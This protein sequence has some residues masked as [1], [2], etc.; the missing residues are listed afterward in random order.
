MTKKT[1]A[2]IGGGLA[3]TEAAHQLS[4]NGIKV[5]LFEMRPK[6]R[7]AIHETPY[8]GEL[9]CSNSLGSEEITSASG[10]LKAELLLL[11]SFY[12]NTVLPFRVPAGASLSIDRLQSAQAIDA[13]ISANSNISVVREE[14]KDIPSGFDAV[15]IAT[16]PLTSQPFA[17]TLQKITKR[18]HL[19]F[20]DATSPVIK[21]DSIDYDKVFRASRYGKGSADFLNIALDES[22]YFDF[23]AALNTAECVPLNEADSPIFYE[24]CLPVEEIARRGPLSLAYGPLKPV[25]LT[26]PRSGRVPFA[27]VQLRQ[28]DLHNQFYQLVGFQTRLKWPEQ[29]RIFSTLPGLNSVKF[30][31]F[32]RMHRNTYINAPLII[33]QF[34]RCKSDPKLVFCGQISGVEGYL[35]SI[36]SGLAASLFLFHHLNDIQ[37]QPLPIESA[38]GSLINAISNGNWK[39][40]CPTNFTFGLLPQEHA[41][42]NSAKKDQKRIKSQRA[43]ECLKNWKILN[44]I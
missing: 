43:L 38:T 30:E 6:E 34:F 25:G 42:K 27:V 11:N 12:L 39:S 24:S 17:Q 44:S 7:T 9:V 15:I 10:L 21:A 13:A 32:G 20:Y 1:V 33:D 31:R 2:V 16:G 26:N 18:R 8:M 5:T 22:Q 36:A 28:D 14:V 35:E 3:G 19:H 40:F 41:A 23:I 37:I 4:K 29:Q